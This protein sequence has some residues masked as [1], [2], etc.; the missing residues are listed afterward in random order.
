[1]RYIIFCLALLTSVTSF[2]QPDNVGSGRAVKFDG[3]DDYINLGNIMDDLTFPFTVSAWIYVDPDAVGA[4]PILV[5]QDNADLYNGFWF[6]VN[7]TAVWIEFGDGKGYN[8]PSYRKGKQAIIPDI[9]GRWVHVCAVARSAYDVD[10]YVNGVD[11]GGYSTGESTDGMASNYPND[12]AKIGYFY[13][14][15]VVYRFKGT[16]DEVRV[17]NRGLTQSEVRNRM[18]K[19]INSSDPGL[20]GDW[21]FNESSGLAIADVS[22]K[23]SSGTMFGNPTRVYSGAPIGDESVNIYPSGSWAGITTSV[24]NFNTFN[25]S[26]SAKGV[27]IY[28]VNSQPS[29]RNGLPNNLDYSLYYG[30]FAAGLQTGTNF[31]ISFGD[32]GLCSIYG[33]ADNGVSTWMESTITTGLTERREVVRGSGE[34]LDLELGSDVVVCDKSSYIITPSISNSSGISFAWN[35]GETTESLVVESS[36]SYKLYAK[37]ACATYVDSIKVYF[38]ETVNVDFGGDLFLCD[39]DTYVINSNI[40]PREDVEFIWS[41]G[42]SSEA[43]VVNQ[44]GIYSLT[45]TSLCNSSADTVAVT[46]T[47]KPPPFSFGE[48][49]ELCVASPKTIRPYL[50]PIAG[51]SYEWQDGSRNEEI[52]VEDFGTF[53]VKV[54][55]LCGVETDSISITKGQSLSGELPNI[56][57]PNGDPLNECFVVPTNSDEGTQ[58]ILYNR[59]GQVVYK[60]LSYR[61]DWN[62]EGIASGVYFYQ[63]N[64]TCD[65]EKRGTVTVSR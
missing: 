14:N 35:T 1:M 34:D 39:Q 2:S 38:S 6:F 61:N 26:G 8:L 21:R 11:V 22:S 15:S 5:S 17:W 27:H 65:G 9:K 37:G 42:A 58:L 33:R 59:W 56:F 3:V 49:L 45:A 44:T 31:D 43:I 60:N 23:S 55:N 16:M 46:F 36:G 30:V 20:V 10:L 63:I 54:S 50:N 52:T 53:W 47:V 25:I 7:P 19:Y 32:G 62:G 12:V 40:E 18:C 57:T 48:D 64:T 4:L 51:F 13:S 28:K 24:D 41:T 29:Q